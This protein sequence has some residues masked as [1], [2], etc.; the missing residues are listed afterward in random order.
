M[1]TAIVSD[2]H[3]G[4]P[5]GE[6]VARDPAIRRA[7]LEEIAGADRL[8]LLG[9]IVE[10]REQP[11]PVTLGRA[12]PFFEEL[13]EA[14]AGRDVVLVPGNH[15]HRFA[16]PLLERVSAAGDGPLGLERVE[17]VTE[18]AAAAIAGWL[19]NAHLTIAYPGLWLREDVYATHGQY[20]DCHMSLPRIECLATATV[21]R[22]F[23]AIPERAAPADYEKVLQPIYG[24]SYGMAQAG[25]AQRA[26]RPSERAWRAISGRARPR[27]RVRQTALKATVAAGIPAGIWALNRALRSDFEPILTAEAITNSG[28]DAAT[29]MCRRL[30]LE[31]IEVITGH[32]HRAGPLDGEPEWALD[33]GG[34]LHNTGSWTFASAFHHPGTPPGPYWPGTV[35][36]VEEHG[37]PRRV[38]LLTGRSREEMK[39]AVARTAASAALA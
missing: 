17:A 12:R 15:D 34:H 36:W 7:L 30:G 6:D 3:L 19:G 11:L 22:I 26:H 21:M 24:F 33:G 28:I 9:D 1:Q 2:L 20:M 18:G 35:T 16:E 38:R 10:L 23:G 25:L 5:T 31:G 4:T 39:T 27:G 8:V 37:P 14:M 32:T 29:E 13:G